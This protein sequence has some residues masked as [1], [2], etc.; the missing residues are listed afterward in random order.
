MK[1][2]R[3]VQLALLQ[4]LCAVCANMMDSRTTTISRDAIDVL[5]DQ[6]KFE[7]VAILD[8]DDAPLI[9]YEATCL[10]EL[11]AELSYA[12]T[13]HDK[14]REDRALM[15]LDRFHIMMQASRDI[16]LRKQQAVS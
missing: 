2:T 13:D 11:L 8:D 4:R 5:R 10:V 14:G 7:R 1:S 15:Y 12:R 6:V 16:A 3:A 9:D